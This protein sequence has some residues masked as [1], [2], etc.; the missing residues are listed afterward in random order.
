MRARPLTLSELTDWAAAGAHWEVRYVDAL[1]AE[2]EFCTCLGEPV[3]RASTEEP[4]LVA[5]LARVRSDR[6]L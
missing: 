5:L 4:Q 3:E 2:V 6:E 1:R